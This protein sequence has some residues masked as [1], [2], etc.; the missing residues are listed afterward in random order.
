MILIIYVTSV[1]LYFIDFLQHNRK[2]NQVAF[3]LLSIVWGLQ[4]LS[5]L[6]QLLAFQALPVF[7]PFNTLFFYSWLLIGLSLLINWFFRMDFL[8]FFT[9]V[10]GFTVM[11]LGL[12]IHGRGFSEQVARQLT[13][14]W[15]MVHVSI[16]IFSYAAFTLSFVLS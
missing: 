9:N 8:L 4:T 2:A 6:A 1:L 14:E 7:P 10:L 5:V 13:S 16:A 11:S 3:W 12:F 15:V